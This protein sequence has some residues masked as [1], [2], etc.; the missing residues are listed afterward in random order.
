MVLNKLL[1]F[2]CQALFKSFPNAITLPDGSFHSLA[3]LMSCPKYLDCKEELVDK[4]A[5]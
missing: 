4:S 5:D 3:I 2:Q 1:P